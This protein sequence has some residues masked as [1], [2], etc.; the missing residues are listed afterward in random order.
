MVGI[1]KI[2]SPSNRIYIGQS[3]DI[4]RRFKSYKRLYVKNQKQTKLHR[5]FMKYGVLNHKFEVILE[6]NELELNKFERFYQEFYNCLEQGLNCNLTASN[7]KSG[8]VC[9]ETLQRMSEVQKGN[10]NWLGKKHTEESKAKISLA[11]KGRKHSDE[12]NKSKGRKGRLGNRKGF[13]S[14]LHPRSVSVNQYDL[15]GNFIKEWICLMDIRRELN[16][17]IGNI[18]SCLKGRLKSYKKFKWEYKKC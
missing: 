15:N 14:E 12:V 3:C 2:T 18:S 16:Y 9:K 17:H 7:D 13:F 10:K 1:Y 5:S 6:C 8:K 11:A 4:E